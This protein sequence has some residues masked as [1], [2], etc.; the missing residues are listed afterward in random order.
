MPLGSADLTRIYKYGAYDIGPDAGPLS[1]NQV[2]DL[3]QAQITAINDTD[4]ERGTTFA[5][6]IQ[7]D[8]D[9]LDTLDAQVNAQAA[10]K[11]IKVLD[12]IEY[13]PGGTSIA[14]QDEM[15]RIADRVKRVLSLSYGST[16]GAGASLL[17]RG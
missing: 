4:A 2:L 6:D 7:S 10:N 1:Y 14:Y 17:Y 12:V 8:L 3:I 11:N 16:S 9:A 5:T 15:Q 13:F